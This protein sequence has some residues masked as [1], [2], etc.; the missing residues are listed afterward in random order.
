[1]CLG[2]RRPLGRRHAHPP[3]GNS[4]LALAP[5]TLST[6]VECLQATER[7]RPGGRGTRV[8]E[9]GGRRRADRAAARAHQEHRLGRRPGW[10]RARP[11]RGARVR[12]RDGRA[13]H[14]H[15][16][17]SRR[18]SSSRSALFADGDQV[19][20]VARAAR[21]RRG[22]RLPRA[23]VVAAAASLLAG[24]VETTRSVRSGEDVRPW[25][26]FRRGRAPRPGGR[27]EPRAP[28]AGRRAPVRAGDGA[29]RRVGD[30][31]A[32]GAPR[33]A[34]LAGATQAPRRVDPVADH[35]GGPVRSRDRARRAVVAVAPVRGR[36]RRQ[37]AGR[38]FVESGRGP[39]PVG[40]DGAA[41]SC[42][43]ASS[44]CSGIALV[45]APHRRSR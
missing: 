1:M 5:L 12:R 37:H 14:R 18:S 27:A 31:R 28:G 36:R 42:W 26:P 43:S 41:R 32:G 7:G 17:G 15:Q 22:V 16:P 11:R 24:V 9:Q 45:R 35:R 23:A 38:R 2:A 40:R 39:H 44:R 34:L 21:V 6:G 10:L 25:T 8:G 30:H 4:T 29:A 3:V 19:P 13:G 33:W 20:A